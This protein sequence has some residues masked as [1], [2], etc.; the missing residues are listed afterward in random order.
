M[1]SDLLFLGKRIRHFRSLA[2]LT[3]DQVS[4][5][6]GLTASQLSLIETGKREPKL[7]ALNALANTF[8]VAVTDLLTGEAPDRRSE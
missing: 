5:A 1:S 6:T 7:T 4:D 2:G 3:L 8:G